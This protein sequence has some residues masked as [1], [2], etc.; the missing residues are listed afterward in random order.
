MHTYIYIY[1]YIYICVCVCVYIYIYIYIYSYICTCIYIYIYT[2][3]LL[4]YYEDGDDASAFLDMEAMPRKGA[5]WASG[6][7]NEAVKWGTQAR[8]CRRLD[9][10]G[11]RRL[12]RA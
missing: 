11:S 1:I 3:D 2:T 9:H 5:A 6:A 8:S 4:T 10:L 7:A 12:K